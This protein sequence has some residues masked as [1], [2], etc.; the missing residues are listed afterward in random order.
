MKTGAAIL[1]IL[2]GAI[3][4]IIGVVSFFVG[5]LGETLG[6][7]GSVGLQ[8][9][10]LALPIAALIGGGIAPKS[11]VVGGLL[12][13][14]SA[15]GILIVLEIGVFSLITAIP[16]GIGALLAFI[17]SATDQKSAPA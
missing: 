15:G 8:I 12:M 13:L 16:I 5:D 1:G 10:S 17:G 11:G 14:V 3:A 7:E 6:I 9:I 4:L 2:G